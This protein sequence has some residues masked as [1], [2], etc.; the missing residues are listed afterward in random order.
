MTGTNPINS[1]LTLLKKLETLGVRLR[2][3]ED[4]NIKIR[5]QSK[6]LNSDLIAQ[7]KQNKTLLISWL[8]DQQVKTDKLNNSQIVPLKRDADGY[9]LSYAQQRLWFIDRLQGSSVEYNMPMALQVSGDFNVD[10]AEQA[11]K[12]IIQRHE[13]LRTTFVNEDDKTLQQIHSTFDFTLDRYDLSSLDAAAQ[14]AE[15]VKL[16]AQDSQKNFDFSQDLMV[17]ASYIQRSTTGQNGVLL[18]NMHHIASDGWSMGIL[19]S[20]FAAQYQSITQGSADSLAPLAIQYADYAHWQRQWLSGEVLETQLGY[21]TKQ[22]DDAPVVHS[23]MLNQPRSESS[24]H[25]AEV[26]VS[27]LDA[28][29]SGQLQRLANDH[30]LTPFMLLHAGLALAL[31][32]HSNSHDIMIGTSVANRTQ[33][34]LEPLIGFFVNTLVLR[35]DTSHQTLADYL[36]HIRHTHLDAQSHQD[37]PFEQLVEHC[38]VTRSTLHSPL[39]Q[40]MFSMNTD[41]PADINIDGVSFT[42]L[43]NTALVAKFDLEIGAQLGADGIE[44]S[45]IYDTSIFSQ[46]QVDTL[47]AHFN[48]LLT[49]MLAT[50]AKALAELEMLSRDEINVLRDGLNHTDATFEQNQLTHELFEAQAELNPEHVAVAFGDQQL[51][52]QQL[53]QRANQLAHYLRAQ[54]VGTETLVGLCAH[55]SPELLVGLLAVLKAGGAY[56]PLDPDY[57]QSRLDSIFADTGMTHLLTQSTLSEK[58]AFNADVHRIAIDSIAMDTQPL[59]SYPQSNPQRLDNAYQQQHQQQLAYVI[60]T[61]GSTGAPKG[62]MVEHRALVNLL[63]GMN[64]RLGGV[65]AAPSKL[66][67]VTTMVFDIAGLE[68]WGP[69]CHGGQIILASKTDSFDPA[70]LNQLMITHN[71]QCMQATPAT[72]QLLLDNQWSG[73]KGL[74]ALSGGE[75]L[76]VDLARQ[77]LPLCEQLWNCYGPTEATIWSLVNQVKTDDLLPGG[78]LLSGGLNNYK[79]YVLNDKQQLLPAGAAGELYIGGASLARG[80]FNQ[81]E[82]TAEKFISHSFGHG[83]G[84]EEQRLYKTGDLARCI[85]NANG[86]TQLAFIGRIDDQVKVRGFRIELGDIES[87]ILQ[88]PAVTATVV[89]AREDQPGQKRLVAYLLSQAENDQL[90][91]QYL[92]TE[93]RQMLQQNLP[94][95][96]QPSALVMLDKFPL[97]ANGKIN[98]KALPAPDTAHLQDQSMAAKTGIQKTLVA[99]W[100]E[101]LNLESVGINTPFFEVGGNSLLTLT[102]QRKISEQTEYQVELTDL[103]SYP[104]IDTLAAF[105][106]QDT[107]DETQPDS[108]LLQTPQDDDIAVIAMACRFPD[109]NTPEQFWHNIQQG[110]ESLQTFSDEQLLAA[111]ISQAEIDQPGYIKS[112]FILPEL[113]NFDAKHFAFTPR[114]VEVMDP[115]QRLLFECVNDALEQGGYAGKGSQTGV[116]VGVGES[117]Y[118]F[119]NLLKQPDLIANLG[120]RGMLVGVSKDFVSTR[121]SHKFDLT[122]PSVNVNTACSTSLVAVHQACASLLDGSSRMALAGGAS[123]TLYR[124]MGYVADEGDI[125]AP[126]GHCRPFDSKGAGTRAGSGAGVVLLKRL[127]DAQADGDMIHAVIK[128]SAINNDGANKVGFT[129]PSVGGQTEV[130][131]TAM[132]KAG[133]TPDSIGY[134][135]AHGTATTLGDPIEISALKQAYAGADSK[136]YNKQYNK[137]QCAIGAVKANI[138]HLD[139]AAGIAG[140]IKTVQLLKHQA[141]PPMVHYQQ[142]NPHIM[143]EDSPFYIP[144]SLQPWPSE[145]GPRRAG[146]SSFGIGGTN[147]HV[148]LEQAPETKVND[149][150]VQASQIQAPQ[151]IVLSAK[152]AGAL[153]GSREKLAAHLAENPGQRLTDIAGTL[154]VSRPGYSHRSFYLS[155]S[156]DNSA[157]DLLQQLQAQPGQQ[158]EVTQTKEIVFMFP[159]QGSQYIEMAA[160]L[161]REQPLFK[162]TLDHCAAL[163]SDSLGVDILT[164]IYPGED[165]NQTSI[166]ETHLTQPVLFAVEYSLATLWMSWG[167]EPTLMTG[168]SVGEYVAAC[169]AGVFSL[170]DALTLVANRGRLMGSVERGLMLSVPLSQDKLQPLLTQYQCSLAAVN[171]R[172]NCVASGAVEAIEALQQALNQQQVDCATL[173]TSHAFHSSMMDGILPEFTALVAAVKPQPPQRPFISNVTG[174]LITPTQATSAE[175]WAEHLRTTVQFSQGLDTLLS[176]EGEDKL[177]LEVGPGKTLTTLLKRHAV[178]VNSTVTGFAS[179]RHK[180][181]QQTDQAFL[182]N[183]LGRL[184]LAGVSLQWS[185]IFAHQPWQRVVLPTCSYQRQRYWVEP[186]LQQQSAA[187]PETPRAQFYQPS[188]QPVLDVEQPQFANPHNWLI[189]ADSQGVAKTLINQLQQQGHEVMVAVRAEQ[190]EHFSNISAEQQI[191]VNIAAEVNYRQLVSKLDQQFNGDVRIVHLWN[192]DLPANDE[193]LAFTATLGMGFLLKNLATC[194]HPVELNMVTV[195]SQ[196]VTGKEVLQPHQAMQAGLC[197][198]A[199]QEN[200]TLT[201]HHID[202]TAQALDAA[203]GAD[204]LLNELASNQRPATIAQRKQLRWSKQINRCDEL[205]IHQPAIALKPQGHYLITGSLE[206]STLDIAKWLVNKFTANITLLTGNE[207]SAKNTRDVTAIGGQVLVLTADVTDSEQMAHSLSEAEQK[208]GTVNGVFY[209]SGNDNAGEALAPISAFSQAVFTQPQL[210]A[211]VEGISVLQQLLDERNHDFV[212]LMS[213]LVSVVGSAGL[214]AYCAASHY[215]DAF[216]RQQHNLG[217]Q[218]WISVNWDTPAV[219][220]IGVLLDEVFKLGYQPQW[221][222]STTPLNQRFN[223]TLDGL[224]ELPVITDTETEAETE[225][226]KAIT[227]EAPRNELEQNLADIWQ[228]LLGFE[229]GIRDNFFELGGDS[230]MAIR[231]LTMLKD[232]IDLAM[233]NFTIEDLFNTPVLADVCQELINRSAALQQAQQQAQLR[234]SMDDEDMMEEGEF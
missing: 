90:E 118:L 47:A 21:W 124:P 80:Y 207:P 4:H 61:S 40:I 142:P 191:T 104:T 120:V 52:Y 22:L 68:L 233:L 65:F 72:W 44:L 186:G 206:S 102:V 138:G 16:A 160:G 101:V 91:T 33:T 226:D 184:W 199:R 27:R 164:V 98:K 153:Q 234:A 6:N 213:S 200:A 168:H 154:A 29:V 220:N 86:G 63:T 144:N 14:Q 95:Y 23:L 203:D 223:T 67:A 66:L 108:S 216:A 19:L 111:G 182:L 210:R 130:I 3:D 159:G 137:Q 228:K 148:I 109:A 192:L 53:N 152:S 57:P 158:A 43:E 75:A 54:G 82:L 2:L 179:I 115:Q 140:L 157:D 166:N 178:V 25:H 105:L 17:R 106:E 139:S 145:D 15:V 227:R 128:G 26:V 94:E 176:H 171:G 70:R 78:L 50:P 41:V 123:V 100:C 131:K 188:W 201:T 162:Q 55:R 5:G 39:F 83:G 163:L 10:A 81:P 127:K 195:D 76:P 13:S 155:A 7:I 119:D 174:L 229:V 150:D 92:E 87:Q 122:G 116:F 38:N 89:V 24:D 169:L 96:M 35:T 209:H 170:A 208:F 73:H 189:F 198:V 60:Y 183:T 1:A 231:V 232:H 167:I 79:H 135:E 56:V 143:L 197:Q 221:L 214:S 175:Y 212:L 196:R 58:L 114:E 31:S 204:F 42:A 84:D 218:R 99:I 69:L 147:A 18:F 51:T 34:A 62:V 230:L 37:V 187:T 46:A 194:H 30:Q 205:Q 85:P 71:V 215:M 161:Y 141:I 133:V 149:N 8:Q 177:F 97:N 225:P 48:Q 134:I 12:R 9:Q 202:L 32:R 126:D 181:D 222:H 45:W 64:E 217:D 165:G 107:V 20:E 151:L 36:A 211:K 180:K 224:G 129:A 190:T 88:H 93:L 132:L 113:K 121:I 117:H 59:D 173:A 219:N 112:G 125:M 74:M 146:V 110:K 11:M 156:S 77:L 193:A 28:D 136:Q 103:F 185:A 49:S 172:E